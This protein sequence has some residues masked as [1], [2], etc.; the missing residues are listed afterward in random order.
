MKY[1]IFLILVCTLF[2]LYLPI[3]LI[4]WKWPGDENGW[5]ELIDSLKKLCCID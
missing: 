4:T 2:W 3:W 1:I 5:E